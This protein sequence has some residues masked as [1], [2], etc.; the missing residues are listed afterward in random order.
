MPR[1]HGNLPGLQGA[2]P[3]PKNLVEKARL[4]SGWL[5][6]SLSLMEQDVAE[7]DMLCLRF[8]Y[9]AFYDLNPKKDA[10]R[11]NQIYEQARRSL[12]QEEIDCTEAEMALFGALQLQVN[13]QV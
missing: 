13:L 9:L 4:N 2:Q 3:R 1:I 10:I 6:S 8:K 5:D 7:Y 11:I 12:L